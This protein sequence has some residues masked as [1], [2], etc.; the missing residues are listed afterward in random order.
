MR[1]QGAFLVGLVVSIVLEHT[2]GASPP[3]WHAGVA[4]VNITPDKPLWMA[5]YSSR[6]KP[7]EGKETD[8]WAKAL[9]LED[10]EGRRGVLITL[11]LVGI[12]RDLSIDICRQLR[13]KYG[14]PR[15]AIV[16]SVSH[17]HCGPVVGDTLRTMYFLSEDQSQLI[18]NYTEQLKA[19]IVDVVG[20]ALSRRAAAQLS[21][22]IGRCDFAVNRR[23]NKEADVPMLIE[24]GQLKG[25]VDHDVPVLA[26]RDAA[27]KL[28]AVAF[29]Y[30]CHATVM[31]YYLWSGDYPGFAQLELESAYPGAIALFWAGCGA[32]QNPLPRRRVELARKYGKQL[33]N[34]VRAVLGGTMEPLHGNWSTVYRELALPYHEVPTRERL[35]EATKS[36]NKYEVN[37][38]RELLRQLETKGSLRGDYPYPIQVWRFGSDERALIWVMLGGEVVVD[39]A[40]RLKQE[41]T[42]G[43]TWVMGYANDVMAYIP[44]LRVLK[45]GGYEGASSMI[46]YGLPSIWGTR[47]EE[48]IVDHVHQAVQ[49]TKRR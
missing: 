48:L 24:Q 33:A 42:P 35:V 38:A 37:R 45:E 41:L 9:V 7:A 10:S 25:P 15:E 44:S 4:K 30:A 34:S 43:R 26:V 46:Y 21:W 16:L 17:T 28:V 13:N 2:V 19:K 29:G 32:D 27:G 14:L 40:L 47:I 20:Q 3:L 11:D 6:T 23:N 31:D 18:E 5:G 22:G 36:S 8:L 12:G 49:A 1:R 39:Y